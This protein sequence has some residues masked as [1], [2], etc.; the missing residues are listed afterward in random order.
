MFSAISLNT[1]DLAMAYACQTNQ[2]F[3]L[4]G[5][6]GTGKTT[7]LH[8]LKSSCH[9]KMAVVAPTGIAAIN[10][11]GV[12]IHSFFQL[13]FGP[14]VPNDGFL[15]QNIHS[16]I[17]TPTRLLKNLRLSQSRKDII[18]ELD[19]LV[20]D[21]VSMLRSDMLDAID[22]ILRQTR[23]KPRVPFGGVQILFIG[24]LFQLP[25]VIKDEEWKLLETY[26]EGPFFFQSRVLKENPPAY[27]ELNK[28]YRQSDPVFVDLLNK[29]RNNQASEAD[30][31]FLHQFYQPGFEPSE[32]DHYIVLTTHNYKADTLNRAALDRLPGAAKSFPA[33]I[34]GEFNEKASPAETNLQMKEG[35]QIM[36]IRNDKGENRRFYNGKLATV[37]SINDESITVELLPEKMPLELEK[38]TWRNIK[39]HYHPEKDQIEEEELG[40]FV[41]YPVRLAWAITI[42]KSQGLTFEKAVVD[43]GASF[44]PGQVY[45]AL[46]RL[47]SLEGLILQSRITEASLHVNP[48]VANF[49]EN[50]NETQEASEGLDSLKGNYTLEVIRNCFRMNGLFQAFGKHSG[51]IFGVSEKDDEK[52]RLIQ[53]AIL[54][55][56]TWQ[57]QIKK[58]MLQVENI[59]SQEEIDWGFLQERL[60]ASTNFFLPEIKQL[61]ASLEK[62][63]KGMSSK[64]KERKEL[65]QLLLQTE[66]VLARLV[67]V[68]AIAEGISSTPDYDTMISCL[69]QPASIEATPE[70]AVA[71]KVKKEKAVK[72]KTTKEKAPKKEKGSSWRETFELYQSGIPL[73]EIAVSRSLAPSTVDGH[74]LQAIIAGAYT[75]EEWIGADKIREIEGAIAELEEVSLNRIKER[76]SR[77]INYAQIRAVLIRMEKP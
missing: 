54:K 47:T 75:L 52:E 25:P 20:I 4:T 44:A 43:A 71:E 41:Q 15:P 77:E 29:I 12:T 9:K 27:L 65:A 73:K 57:D 32:S 14:F 11:G 3:F 13:P 19:L 50:R 76:I 37:T 64:K 68:K 21:E 72:D 42:H 24:D 26:Y 58:F 36:F 55:I 74:L 38:E 18:E 30:L 23:Q 46:S 66:K 61:S 28:I 34:T 45:V 1:F 33:T 31:N 60:S 63:M 59:F 8:L 7:F 35:A 48:H 51:Q 16:E 70:P 10:A 40:T 2:S 17:N 56:S 69:Q 67:K 62:Q 5:K 6:A 49:M 22:L 53:H 39:Y